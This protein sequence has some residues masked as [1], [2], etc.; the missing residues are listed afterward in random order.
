MKLSISA[1]ANGISIQ[2][3]VM[4]DN[5]SLILEVVDELGVKHTIN[6]HSDAQCPYI[7]EKSAVQC[8]TLADDAS[9]WMRVRTPL[10]IPQITD[11][12]DWELEQE[13][14]SFVA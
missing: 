10:F 13:Y 4:Q 1:A 2:R 8:D 14:K 9:T 3:F 5:T 12:C 6:I 11:E 7:K